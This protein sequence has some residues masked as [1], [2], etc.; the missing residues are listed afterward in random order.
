MKD[1][2]MQVLNQLKDWDVDF[3]DIRRSMLY[4]TKS[5]KK[6]LRLLEMALIDMKAHQR[7]KAALTNKVYH[8][9]DDLINELCD[10]YSIE[11]N[12]SVL[13]IECIAELLGHKIKN[14]QSKRKNTI[15]SKTSTPVI[16]PFTSISLDKILTKNEA[17][18]LIGRHLVIPFGITVI[19]TQAFYM[20]H[21]LE[22]VTLP[23]AVKEIKDFAFA[24]CINLKNI[25][26]PFGI[27]VGAYAFQSCG[28]KNI[29]IPDG[30]TKIGAQA[31]AG[32]SNL[33]SVTFPK[34]VNEIG[35][36]AFA[37]C[38]NLRD[39]KLP[40]GVRIGEYAFHLCNKLTIQNLQSPASKTMINNKFSETRVASE[41]IREHERQLRLQEREHSRQTREQEIQLRLQE[42]EHSRQMK[43]QERQLRLQGREHSRQMREQER[44]LRLQEMEHKRQLRKQTRLSKTPNKP[45]NIS[46]SNSIFDD[47]QFLDINSYRTILDDYQEMVDNHTVAF[48]NHASVFASNNSFASK[49]QKTNDGKVSFHNQD[50]DVQLEAVKNMSNINSTT[51]KEMAIKSQFKEVQLLAVQKMSNINS[52]HLKEIAI[53]SQ[54]E[55]VQLAVIQKMS[56]IN[57]THLKEIAAKSQYKSVHIAIISKGVFI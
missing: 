18:K 25:N 21:D 33:E 22:S 17:D 35:D 48:D 12:T 15:K 40:T 54:F 46:D 50:F 28:L 53:K 6:I 52:T 49:K 20:R 31:F 44:Q 7:L 24:G 8:A 27:K 55:N 11:K 56:N 51:L 1:E 10:D 30:V 5:S 14:K 29:I 3:N 19:D 41:Q 37:G 2:I 47:S 42:R 39:I 32:L 13:I 26:L 57:I 23:E 16:L 45:F 43:E 9:V 34:T 4:D 38:I 36:F